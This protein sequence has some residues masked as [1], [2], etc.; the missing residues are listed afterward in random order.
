M[1]TVT[2]ANFCSPSL[3]FTATAL[4]DTGAR[5]DRPYIVLPRPLAQAL[6]LHP[7]GR[8]VV[9]TMA[10]PDFER[11]EEYQPAVWVT[12]QYADGRGSAAPFLAPVLAD[13][14]PTGTVPSLACSTYLF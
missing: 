13:N 9:T 3:S 14:V 5:L 12:L 4:L 2:L 7:T 10:S 6:Q 11:L 8:S 1:N